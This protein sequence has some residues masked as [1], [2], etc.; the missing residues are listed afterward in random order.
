L[1]S[2]TQGLPPKRLQDHHIPLKN[3]AEPFSIRPYR[4]PHVQKGEIER[5][6]QDMLRQGIIQHSNSPF[7]PHVLLVKKKE[8]DGECVW[9][10]DSS[11]SSLSRTSFQYP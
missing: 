8:E 10:T 6:I 5:L 9:I 2:D 4:Y 1:F 7:A 3:D 11:T